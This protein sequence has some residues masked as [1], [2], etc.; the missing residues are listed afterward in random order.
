MT[1]QPEIKYRRDIDG[2]RAIAVLAVVLYH[3][4]PESIRGGFIGVDVF[5]VISGY[6]ISLILLK[7]FRTQT[8]SLSQFYAKRL[9][10][11]FPAL[12]VMVL[13]CLAFGW[14]SLT[15]T[16][17]D[18]LGQHTTASSLFITNFVLDREAGYFD[19]ASHA[20]PL[21]HLWSLAIEEQFY[22]IWPLLF[23]GAY[24]KRFS[25]VGFCGVIILLS[26]LGGLY[27][28]TQNAVHAFYFPFCRGWELISGALL[29]GIALK[30]TGRTL[31]LLPPSLIQK[32]ASLLG[33]LMILGGSFL[34]EKSSHFPGWY[35]LFPVL[36]TMLI[37]G[38]GEKSW[39]NRH[40]LS[41]PLLVGL[42]LISYPLY[43]W[44]WPLLSFAY[45]LNGGPPE[46][47]LIWSLLFLSLGLA[48]LTYRFIE[49]PIRH[50]TSK[51][52]VWALSF[53]LPVLGGLGYLIHKNNGY[54]GRRANQITALAPQP[55]GD[56]RFL[57]FRI[58]CQSFTKSDRTD[59]NEPLCILSS[60][61]PKILVIGDSHALTVGY[62]GLDPT[63]REGV[64]LDPPLELALFA[65][66][67]MLPFI[68]YVNYNPYH[69]NK[70][71][72]IAY[73]RSAITYLDEV[74][75]R[76]P[77]I[78]YVVFATRG[79]IYISGV[80]FG[81]ETK[82]PENNG[83]IIAPQTAMQNSESNQEAFVQGYVEV[84]NHVLSQGKQVIFMVDTPE[85]GLDPHGCLKR[86][87]MEAWVPSQSCQVSRK[88]LDNR[89]KE[90][91]QLIEKIRQRVPS[92][93]IYDPTAVFCDSEQ[94]FAQHQ[95]KILYA[96][97]HHLTT[98]GAILVGHD[99]KKWLKRVT[100]DRKR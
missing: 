61:R 85:L 40:L 74:L 98:D 21:L 12:V 65:G 3:A 95:G 77:T 36:G 72:R 69:Q 59:F 50:R 49:M 76:Y 57:K 11:I 70:A 44:H 25:R 62:G 13:A 22:I 48:W 1:D 99:F 26:F 78:E 92:L 29:T 7:G 4:F 32:G 10:R 58:D 51:G 60:Q 81:I 31:P 90:Y 54:G 63:D 97:T 46:A 35:A 80:G 42:G 52:A 67:S 100:L 86:P 83:W 5:F 93:L 14:V 87:V 9:K 56:P 18:Q 17:Y 30:K 91:R 75:R 8:F 89:E 47:Q 96:D 68:N 66:K 64:N 94:C 16:E 19:T 79:P 33:L 28:L 39:V 53:C 41:N 84:I 71:D 82:I 38:A 55:H 20:K 23:Y 27:T 73:T 43:L 37:I 15:D 88:S 24:Q 6:L 2:L 34:I 45:I